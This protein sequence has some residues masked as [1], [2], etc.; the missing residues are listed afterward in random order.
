MNRP[1]WESPAATSRNRETSHVPWGSY[2]DAGQAKGCDRRASRF[3]KLLNGTWKFR[4]YPNPVAAPKFF[5]V[6]FD[7]QAW[8]DLPV[9]SNWQLH[10]D[11]RPIYTNVQYP[12]PVD[13]P[14]SPGQNPTGC[15]R[16]TFT[17]PESWQDRQVF[18]VLESVDSAFHI[19]VNGQEI[20]FSTDSRLPAE[21]DLT[22]HLRAGTNTLAV[23]VLRVAASTYLEDQD[24]W[25]MSGIQRDVYLIAKPRT[26]LRDFSVGTTFD[27]AYRNAT[28]D[29]HVLTSPFPKGESWS[30]TAQLFDP[31]GHAVFTAPLRDTFSELIPPFTSGKQ[32]S[33]SARITATVTLPRP[34]TTETPSLYS[35][36]LT[37]HAPDDRP[38]DHESCRVGFRQV[39]IR[40]GILLLNGHRLLVRGVDQHEH[41]PD[42]GR[43]L[44]EAYMRSELTLMKRL[45]FNAI[46]TSHYPHDTRWYDLCDELGI[47]VVDEA[48]LETHGLWGVL[49]NDPAWAAAYLERATRM[50]L[51]DRNHP[52]VMAWSLGNESSVGPHHAAMAAWI[53]AFDGTRPV[54]YESGNPGPAVSDILVP[55]YPQLDWVRDTLADPAERRPLIMCEYAY[56]KG[57][58]TGNFSKFWDLILTTPRFQGGFVWDWADKGLTRTQPDGSRRWVYG[59]PEGE[60]PHVERMCLNGVVFTDLSLKPGAYEIWKVQAPVRIEPIDAAETVA[61]RFRIFNLHLVSSLAHLDLEWELQASGVRVQSGRMPLPEAAPCEGLVRPGR[62]VALAL[63]GQTTEQTSAILNVPFA[64][65]VAIPGAEYY[66]NLR[67]VLNRDFP[68]APSGHVVAWDQIRLPIALPAQTATLP[69]AVHERIKTACGAVRA[70]F[71]P[72]AGTLTSLRINQFELLA[73]GPQACFYR[74]PTDIDEGQAAP[75]S[76]AARWQ[77]AGLDRLIR[78]VN[79]CQVIHLH[80]QIDGGSSEEIGLRVVFNTT[81]TN[82]DGA[83]LFQTRTAYEFVNGL[84]TVE[85]DV[86]AADALPPL[87]RVGLELVLVAGLEQVDW[88]GRGP[89]ENYPDRKHAA[90]VGLH[91]ASVTDLF[92][93]YL[94]PTENGARQDVRWMALTRKDGAGL[95]VRAIDPLFGFSAQHHSHADLAAAKHMGDLPRRH[96]VFLH[97]D[98]RHSGLGG[99]TG[100]SPN[101][102]PEYQIQ[103]GRFRFGFVLE[104]LLPG[105]TLSEETGKP[106]A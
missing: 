102:H 83:A 70:E 53:R 37:L 43:V 46:R 91:H 56:D 87:P 14:L 57:N 39:E 55:M 7:A 71:D 11:D 66:L 85:V 2:E 48:N 92:T 73:H 52:C 22:P 94:Y 20:G 30:V 101:I 6:D 50:V 41:H 16:T 21:F 64:P 26:H 105:S 15:Y 100:W 8:Q 24:Y 68:W 13:P 69:P 60:A 35:L 77:K 58:S 4:L 28:L 40:D 74:A 76:Y 5:A 9:P 59:T 19:W 61:G 10:G 3:V 36:V 65:P 89:F 27:R 88:F 80:E 79:G 63:G 95:R 29:L 32:S 67:C 1:E 34:W 99:D 98:A 78:T 62:T 84:L 44:S 38:V 72:V 104:P 33:Y 49:S 90:M 45:N 75:Q 81:S 51:R 106:G 31:D 42:T 25:Q 54:Q 17:L 18:I 12:F 82:P 93:P 103:P 86:T 23:R 96:E 97:L 47:L